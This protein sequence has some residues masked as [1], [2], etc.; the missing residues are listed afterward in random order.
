MSDPKDRP[1]P[2]PAE[3]ARQEGAQGRNGKGPGDTVPDGAVDA[4]DPKV[5]DIADQVHANA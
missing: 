1:Q 5:A 2:V 3:T 4:S